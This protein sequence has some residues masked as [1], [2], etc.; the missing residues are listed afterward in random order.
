[1]ARKGNRQQPR[2]RVGIV[3]D[4][5]TERIYF[6]NVRDTDRPGN[7]AIFPDSP[8]KFGS[9]KGVLAR[10]ELLAE[11]YDQVYALIDYDKVNQDNQQQAYAAAKKK[12][13]SIGVIVVENNPCFELW[14]LCISYTAKL[15]SDCDEVRALR[16]H[17]PNY[18][19]SEKF[20]AKAELY[21]MYKNRILT[22]AIPNAKDSK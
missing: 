21:K 17:I 14:L 19:K 20:I 12:V 22:H 16:A 7:L 5:Q 8:R 3:G 11:D 13:E 10:A 6:D 9:Y 1:V 4:G 18:C 15:F 2:Y